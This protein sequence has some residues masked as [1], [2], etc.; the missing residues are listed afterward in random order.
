MDMVRTSVN[1][2]GNC[3]GSCVMARIEGEFRGESWREE[4]L[5]RRLAAAQSKN[6]PEGGDDYADNLSV[7]EGVDH[8]GEH[9]KS[10]V[11]HHDEKPTGYST[12][13]KSVEIETYEPHQ[14]R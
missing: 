10:V 13:I 12:S 6:N 9:L 5:S 11:V 1:V 8:H 4:E 2:L 7:Q 3:L 14:K